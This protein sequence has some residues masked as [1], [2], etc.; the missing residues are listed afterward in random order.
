MAITAKNGTGWD[1]TIK[2]LHRKH[3][4]AQLI[5]IL[6]R[7]KPV[8]RKWMEVTCFSTHRRAPQ[9]LVVVPN[10]MAQFDSP[11]KRVRVLLY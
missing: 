8:V 7:Y 6:S 9:K 10:L 11:G 5:D 3:V 2:A 1:D 4:E